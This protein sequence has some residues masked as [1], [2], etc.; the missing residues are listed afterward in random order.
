MKNL[1][2]QQYGLRAITEQEM[3]ETT[4]GEFPSV[5]TSLIGTLI[6]AISPIGAVGFWVGYFSNKE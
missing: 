5:R 6:Q 4:G 1:D 2:L 3:L